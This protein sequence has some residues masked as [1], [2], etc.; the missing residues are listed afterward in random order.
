VKT[1]KSFRVLAVLAITLALGS[2]AHAGTCDLTVAPGTEC[3]INT[4][5]FQAVDPQATG[6]GLIDP[7][8]QVSGAG[9]LTQTHAYN[10]TVNNVLNNTSA[11]NWNHELLL[12]S[13]PIVNINGTD[14]YEFVLDINESVGQ[15][16]NYL[17]LDAVQIFQS[18]IPNQSVQTFGNLH[19]AGVVDINGT[20]AYNLDSNEDNV[21]LLDYSF[22]FGS[23]SGD[24]NL[25]VPVSAFGTGDYVY[26]YS[27][28]GGAGVVGDRNYGTSDGFEEWT[29]RGTSTPVPEP[30][31]LILLGTGLLGVAGKVRRRM[32]KS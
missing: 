29:T 30:A 4:A 23:G 16:E 32:K 3:T 27:H 1:T 13:V 19:G 18:A 15:G 28:F 11:D 6:T 24:M 9:N 8:V 7:F 25:Y 21:V 12:T 31:T 14:Y 20:L 26:L 22:G 10:T 5:I 2:L 17:S